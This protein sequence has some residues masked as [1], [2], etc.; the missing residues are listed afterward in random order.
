MTLPL[1][2]KEA[3]PGG[4]A[5]CADPIYGGIV[6]SQILAAS[7]NGEGSWFVIFNDSEL[8][9][10]E[11]LANRDAAFETFFA[12]LHV[13]ISARM[14]KCAGLVGVASEA[15]TGC[16]FEKLIADGGNSDAAYSIARGKIRP[17]LNEPL[18]LQINLALGAGVSPDRI[19]KSIWDVNATWSGVRASYDR[20]EQ[21]IEAVWEKAG[22]EVISTGG[23]FWAAAI[24][25]QGVNFF[26][27][28]YAESP[29]PNPDFALHVSGHSAATGEYLDFSREVDGLKGVM[30]KLSGWAESLQEA[31]LV[32]A[33]NERSK[34]Q[35]SG[36]G[37]GR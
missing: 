24:T 19:A 4:L 14:A 25:H 13:A 21:E 36:P 33:S 10:I 22:F 11:G 31:L 35:S 16:L 20:T 5:T 29:A 30:S 37:V 23:G 27:T 6:D 1:G 15:V 8:A 32:S 7:V 28:D 34:P 9:P 18:Q 12:S 17:L 3:T 26:I 2:W